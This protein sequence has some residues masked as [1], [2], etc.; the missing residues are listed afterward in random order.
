[1]QFIWDTGTGIVNIVLNSVFITVIFALLI[2]VF[3][4]VVKRKFGYIFLITSYVLTL[5]CYL[6]NLISAL[7]VLSCT[8]AAI[9][10]ITAY[11]NIGELRRYLSNPFKRARVSNNKNH[12]EKIFDRHATYQIIANAVKT[13]SGT[14][15]G[16]IITFEKESLLDDFC[17]NGVKVDAP[18]TA[19]L[20]VTIFY[21]GTRL[22]D[23]AVIIHGDK[24]KSAAVFYTPSTKAF[25]GKYGSRHRAAIGIS[26]VSD[27]VTVVVSEET[28]RISIA[29]NGQI[30]S[31]SE[32]NFL[33]VFENYM[34]D[35]NGEGK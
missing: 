20:L 4:I 30:D 29:V 9:V 31:V 21:P 12:V 33:R 24:I 22:H 19:E 6:L 25:T 10:T 18:I 23:G 15:T 34:M 28:G 17:K 14:K 13:L 1:M 5:G 11:T 16:A 27:S 7:I 35:S 26:E 3:A 2:A 8:T 32:A